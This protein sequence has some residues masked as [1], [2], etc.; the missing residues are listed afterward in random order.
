MVQNASVQNSEA[1]VEQKSLTPRPSLE[2]QCRFYFPPPRRIAYETNAEAARELAKSGSYVLFSSDAF[3]SSPWE[4]D[5]R[6]YRR[7]EAWKDY[8]HLTLSHEHWETAILFLHERQVAG[9]KPRL[10]CVELGWSGFARHRETALRVTTVELNSYLPDLKEMLYWCHEEKDPI[11]PFLHRFDARCYEGIADNADPA[12]FSIEMQ[13]E[14]ITAV[15]DGWL[16][17]SGYVKLRMRDPELL[18]QRFQDLRK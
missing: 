6:A 1:A 4:S 14:S 17:P 15:V 13:Y 10:V 3:F 9:Y 12:H 11:Q 8:S 16:L 7:L 5:A 18:M 2:E